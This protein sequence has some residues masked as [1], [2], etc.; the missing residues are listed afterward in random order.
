MKISPRLVHA[1]IVV[2]GFAFLALLA[3]GKAFLQF[4]KWRE[5][6]ESP[7]TANGR[8]VRVE[9]PGDKWQ[10][11]EYAFDFGPRT[12]RGTESGNHYKGSAI[13]G[14]SVT[15]SFSRGNPTVST[16]DLAYLKRNALTCGGASAVLIP[17]VCLTAL[18]FRKI[19]IRERTMGVGRVR[20]AFR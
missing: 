4:E 20:R 7:E 3:G 6:A 8:I 19:M 16:L 1:V 14:D 2:G 18:G 11:V 13:V 15:V 17:L 5:I 12:Y 10:N 9:R